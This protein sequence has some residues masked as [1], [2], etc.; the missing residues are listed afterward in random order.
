MIAGVERRREGELKIA[1]D[2]GRF[3]VRR[4]GMRRHKHCPEASLRRRRETLPG[5]APGVEVM[6]AKTHG[7]KSGHVLRR[8]PAQKELI[9]ALHCGCGGPGIPT[10]PYRIGW[11]CWTRR[12]GRGMTAPHWL[13]RREDIRARQPGDAARAIRR[14]SVSGAAVMSRFPGW[15]RRSSCVPDAATQF[16]PP[17]IDKRAEL[18]D[19]AE[20]RLPAIAWFGYG[21]ARLLIAS[22]GED[23]TL[24]AKAQRQGK[25]SVC[26]LLA[27]EI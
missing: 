19:S 26:A 21:Q 5:A 16:R 1:S 9:H 10:Q 27:P 22:I 8:V 14:R 3:A 6:S 2:D 13:D 18:Q 7:G 20:L 23:S 25:L 11:R 24:R 15:R 17:F 12:T 4:R